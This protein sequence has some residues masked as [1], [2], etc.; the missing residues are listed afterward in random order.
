MTPATCPS[1][2]YQMTYDAIMAIVVPA[3]RMRNW[4]VDWPD[5]RC[6]A[7]GITKAGK[8]QLCRYAA[9]LQSERRAASLEG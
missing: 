7:K 9:M 6:I 8:C 2:M 1:T 4:K 3:A 5:S